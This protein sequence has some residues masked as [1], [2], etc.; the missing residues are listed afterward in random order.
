MY[1]R[2]FTTLLLATLAVPADATPAPHAQVPIVYTAMLGGLDAAYVTLNESQ[3]LYG[4]TD[5]AASGIDVDQAVLRH[6]D[7]VM[8]SAGHPLE[9][10]TAS[11]LFA[12]GGLRVQPGGQLVP[13]LRSDYISAFQ[14]PDA[15]R[16]WLVRWLVDRIRQDGRMPDVRFTTGRLFT[17]VGP[18]GQ[19]VFILSDDGSTP[20]GDA[21]KQPYAWHWASRDSATLTRNLH[22]GTIDL[23]G[24]QLGGAASRVL[25]SAQAAQSHALRVDLGGLLAPDA[26]ND[27]IDRVAGL[28]LDALVPWVDELQ[29]PHDALVRLSQ[30]APLV[31]A[32][33]TPP[34]GVQLKPYVIGERD[35][36][37]IG[38]IGLADTDR[39]LDTG[40]L[41]ARAGWHWKSPA[42]ALRP[43]L[44][45]VRQEGVDAVVILTNL[46][47]SDLAELRRQT[48]GIAV[49]VGCHPEHTE[50]RYHERFEPADPQSTRDGEPWLVAGVRT[51]QVGRLTLDFGARGLQAVDN[52]VQRATDREVPVADAARSW[53][54]REA[55]LAFLA[56]HRE[57]LLPDF[58]DLLAIAPKAGVYKDTEFDEYNQPQW[59]RLAASSLRREAGAEIAIVPKLDGGSILEGAVPES[60]AEAWLSNEHLVSAQLT[61]KQIRMLL[62][63]EYLVAAGVDAAKAKVGGRKL[64]DDEVYRVVTTA[65]IAHSEGY[66]RAFQDADARPLALQGGRLAPTA[67]GATT[68]HDAVLARLVGLKQR[69]GGFTADYCK[70]LVSM[71]Q[72]DGSAIAP[73]WVLTVKPLEGTF[74]AFRA[75]SRDEFGQV[76]DSNLNNANSTL[77]GGKGKVSIAYEAASIDWE[78][79]IVSA[80]QREELDSASG[81]SV[82]EPDNNLALGTELRLKVFKLDMPGDTMDLVPFVKGNYVTQFTPTIDA[83]TGK[84]NPLEQEYDGIGGVVLQPGGWFKELRLGAIAKRDVDRPGVQAGGELETKFKQSLGPADFTLDLDLKQYLPTTQDTPADIGFLGECQP[85]FEFPL[86]GGLSLSVGADAY[87]FNGKVPQTQAYGLA[88]TPTIGLTYNAT[89]KPQVGLLY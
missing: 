30:R 42:E 23:F 22:T 57:A 29:M 81:P 36:R 18:H 63:A 83:S 84:A 51:E 47:E 60:T 3:Y 59:S 9:P 56:K 80:Y 43:A 26:S 82:Q 69:Y 44:D 48:T 74:Q 28:H 34:A 89:W 40:A 79:T 88:I 4:D 39:L 8:W 27:E 65:R 53:S 19:H 38:I 77:I 45:A 41:N 49:I 7:W 1:R 64:E 78:N 5:V 16:P 75:T 66:R 70:A 12:Q 67:A 14:E 24:N 72:D 32:N 25:A 62:D 58:R 6:G 76:R 20:R 31:A 46:G 10:A 21:L 68:L 17:A 13:E 37:R 15:Q 85:A 11:G 86:W 2:F 54:Q 52:D 71:L 73:R 35:G 87:V 33:L 61:G 55:R 50:W